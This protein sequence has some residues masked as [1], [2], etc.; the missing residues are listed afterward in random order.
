MQFEMFLLLTL[1]HAAFVIYFVYV[2]AR[3][4][5]FLPIIGLT[6]IILNRSHLQTD[7]QFTQEQIVQLFSRY[8]FTIAWSCIML[9][10]W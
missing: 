6:S 8:A 1:F 5:A 3:W 4:L 10:G 2:G 9:G 7:Q